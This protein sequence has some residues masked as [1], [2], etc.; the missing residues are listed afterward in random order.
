MSDIHWFVAPTEF[1]DIAMGITTDADNGG[2]ADGMGLIYEVELLKSGE[3]II[4]GLESW[5][6]VELD[7]APVHG[8]DRTNKKDYF[9]ELRRGNSIDTT[10]LK[11]LRLPKG[12]F[13]K[14][15]TSQHKVELLQSQC[16]LPVPVTIVVSEFCI[17][18]ADLHRLGSDSVVII[19]ESFAENWIVK[20]LSD[21]GQV[22]SCGI[23]NR[24]DSVVSRIMTNEYQHARCSGSVLKFELLGVFSID[25]ICIFQA[26]QERLFSIGAIDDMRCRIRLNGEIAGHGVPVRVGRG[27]A[28]SITDWASKIGS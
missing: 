8:R 21:S 24:H 7:P 27:Y 22:I 28:F 4:A 10:D 13:E 3:S 15:I 2:C 12:V 1:G 26:D 14:S 19:P 9:V 17:G 16:W 23:L 6:E 25:P 11:L 5:L 18:D 20:L